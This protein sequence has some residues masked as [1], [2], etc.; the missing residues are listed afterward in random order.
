MLAASSA[1]IAVLSVVRFRKA[2]LVILLGSNRNNGDT[3]AAGDSDAR[4]DQ[5]R[6][7]NGLTVTIHRR[8]AAGHGAALEARD[9][10]ADRVGRAGVDGL[11]RYREQH[12]ALRL[13]IV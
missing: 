5:H 1:A 3:I 7:G 9:V 8:R 6:R 13:R 10:G 2:F 12:P 11:R 4:S